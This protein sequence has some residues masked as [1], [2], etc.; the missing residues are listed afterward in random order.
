MSKTAVLFSGQGAQY[1]GMGHDLYEAD[2]QAKALYDLGE[3]LRP[4]TTQVCFNGESEE[5][6]KTENTQ[7]ALFLTDLAFANALKE[8]G[9]TADAVAGSKEKYISL[10]FVDYIA[11][12]FN[13]KEIKEK[14]DELFK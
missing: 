11:K 10:G 7:P 12:P 6:T 5:L 4:G 14:L 8:A 9:I 13:R 1:V 2:A 3:A